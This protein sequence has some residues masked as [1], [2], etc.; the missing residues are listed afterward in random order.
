MCETGA[1][2]LA[3]GSELQTQP[4]SRL[5]MPHNSLGPDLSFFDK[6]MEVCLSA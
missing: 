3:D 4:T 1:I 6:K 5:D 2:F